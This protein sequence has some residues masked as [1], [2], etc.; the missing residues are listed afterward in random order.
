MGV[1]GVRV[2]G[3]LLWPRRGEGEFWGLV[4]VRRRGRWVVEGVM[5]SMFDWFKGWG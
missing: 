5:N 2:G 1:S 3:V 4:G